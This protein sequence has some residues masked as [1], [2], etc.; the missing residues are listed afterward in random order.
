MSIF[1]VISGICK[2][3][4]YET[5]VLAEFI[6]QLFTAKE[7]NHMKKTTFLIIISLFIANSSFAQ[8]V[9]LKKNQV[10]KVGKV[11]CGVIAKKWVNVK[12]SGK[13]YLVVKK[14][15][16]NSKKVCS[17]LLKPGS[18][19]NLNSLPS[20]STVINS[21]KKTKAKAFA[22][23]KAVSGTPPT[24][25]E[26]RTNG[27]IPTFWRSGVISGI[28][29]GSPTQQQCNEFFSSDLDGASGGFSACYLTQGVG[30][31]VSEIARAGNVL[32][33]MKNFPKRDIV[34]A[35]AVTLVSGSYP[36]GNIENLFSVP[37][38]SRAKVVKVILSQG[39]E[40]ASNMFLRI[41]SVSQNEASGDQYKF[42]FWA[43][44]GDP[45]PQEHETSRITAGGEFITKSVSTSDEGLYSS[46]VRGFLIL[47][48]GKLVFD[49]SRDRTAETIGV[50]SNS[51]H[52]SFITINSSNEV[53][54]KSYDAFGSFEPRK[55]YSVSNFSGS[56]LTSLRFLEGAYK[57][58]Q[59]GERTYSSAIEYRDSFYTS[60]PNNPY[61]ESVNSINFATDSFYATAPSL[62]DNSELSCSATADVVVGLDMDNAAMIAVANECEG[63]RIDG[64][65]DFCSS[66]DLQ[67]AQQN[68][69]SVCT[70]PN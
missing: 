7:K 47:E 70:N 33:Y 32:C 19:K 28:L 2:Y 27:A 56:G 36:G 66:N 25:S 35:G 26:I 68:Y 13:K 38:G 1:I 17:K 58:L 22:G 37:S 21:N 64:S 41:N 63:D 52:K 31:S 3:L 5:K 67:T 57:E 39:S 51:N 45:T 42:D 6:R 61:L 8:P 55:S 46:S 50:R 11:L 14:A 10:T 16:P 62:T 15:N 40:G 44:E 48:A 29:S 20:A 12:K 54:S 23:I 49:A 60:A 59:Q 65:I 24:L 18:V 43:C 34:N 30:Q 4:L 53:S 69:R 9:S